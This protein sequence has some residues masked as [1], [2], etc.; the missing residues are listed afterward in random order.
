METSSVIKKAPD[1]LALQVLR[2]GCDIIRGLMASD[3]L[4][5][6][7]ADGYLGIP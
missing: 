3:R 7:K 6:S 4:R 2:M 1:Y 5:Q